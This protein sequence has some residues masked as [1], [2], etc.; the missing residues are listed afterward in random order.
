MNVR[1]YKCKEKGHF[2]NNCPVWKKKGKAKIVEEEDKESIAKN[3]KY[4]IGKLK[5]R[6]PYTQF[7]RERIMT[8]GDYFVLGTENS[9]WNEFWYFN[10]TIS[11]HMSPTRHLFTKRRNV[12]LLKNTSPIYFTYMV[13]VASN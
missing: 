9:F 11:K 10:S 7:Y 3:H 8:S 2:V 4:M 5:P 6:K 1:C 12:S 13:L